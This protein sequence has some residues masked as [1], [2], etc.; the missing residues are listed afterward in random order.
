MRRANES[1]DCRTLQQTYDDIVERG[2]LLEQYLA[3][4]D[5][6]TAIFDNGDLSLKQKVVGFDALPLPNL[7]RRLVAGDFYLSGDRLIDW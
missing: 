2:P 1:V 4:G 6:S 5:L 7:P 3:Y